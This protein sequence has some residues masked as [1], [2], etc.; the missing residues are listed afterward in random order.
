MKI[1]V[2]GPPIPY[3][4]GAVGSR[5]MDLR[6]GGENVIDAIAFSSH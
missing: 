3:L 4:A 6:N 5:I 2:I 1:I